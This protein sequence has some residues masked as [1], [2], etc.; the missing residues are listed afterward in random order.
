MMEEDIEQL[1][2]SRLEDNAK[3]LTRSLRSSDY[4]MRAMRSSPDFLSRVARSPNSYLVRTM[5]ST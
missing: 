2:E 5:R 4:L 3:G 1:L